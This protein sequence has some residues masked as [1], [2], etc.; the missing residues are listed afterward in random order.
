MTRSPKQVDIF[1]L[2]NP[3]T[4]KK[5]V[6]QDQSLQGHQVFQIVQGHPRCKEYELFELP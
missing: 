4:N 3:H 6:Q 1:L 5:Y 2:I